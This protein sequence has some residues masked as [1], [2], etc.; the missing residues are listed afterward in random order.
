ME[1][2]VS[3]HSPDKLTK[4]NDSKKKAEISAI[5]EKYNLK[6][7]KQTK[8]NVKPTNFEIKPNPNQSNVVHISKSLPTTPITLPSQQS[9]ASGTKSLTTSPI[10]SGGG[11]TTKEISIKNIIEEDKKKEQ[12]KKYEMPKAIISNT[13]NPKSKIN[14]YD[15]IPTVKDENILPPKT[16]TNTNTN[17]NYN[18]P[19]SQF[20]KLPLKQIQQPQQMPM[21]RQ[22]PIQQQQ[23]IQKPVAK[24][25]QYKTV[26]INPN[27][28]EDESQYYKGEPV[29][30]KSISNNVPT[31]IKNIMQDKLGKDPGNINDFRT[32]RHNVNNVDN[33]VRNISI[34]K[35]V[36][37]SPKNMQNIQSLQNMQNAPLVEQV[38]TPVKGSNGNKRGGGNSG[39][40]ETSELSNLEKQRLLLQRQ[41]M[42]ELQKFKAKKAEIIKLNNRKKEIE[43]MRSI[44]DEKQKL[45]KIQEKQ[46]ELNNIY[47]QQLH[48]HSSGQN[49]LTTKNII[50]NVDAKRT[51]KNI[52]KPNVIDVPVKIE[53][54]KVDEKKVDEK[55][56]E[57]KKVEEK[58]VEEKK[59]DEKKA[60]GKE[61]K[62]ELKLDAPLEY[63][64]KKD[65]PDIKWP[66][67]NE[68]YDVVT[69]SE[70]L[71][72]ILGAPNFFNKKAQRDKTSKE[73]INKTMQNL[74]G[75]KHI[76][77][78]KDT[79]I[80]T[81]YKILSYEKIKWI[82]E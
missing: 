41:Q 5:L 68:L 25:P 78:F 77:K 80:S 20:I 63:Y 56:V 2:V 70:S 4:I 27:L 26:T 34:Q 22:M 51:K 18:K 14:I 12:A 3:V 45:R 6:P 71:T 76:D 35:Q 72:T 46:H 54:K 40:L 55:K 11:G 52:Q 53:E 57:E 43:L 47:N 30:N 58:K 67:K 9:S 38:L 8:T 82:P 44:E 10:P 23:N 1:K 50:Y 65:K 81:I 13:N 39:N 62:K 59:V 66:T 7:T 49:N 61:V 69:F 75:F 15:F 60:G 31:P 28:S 33:V 48:N 19:V 73:D 21:Q 24:E 32:I 42:V 29:S 16:N 36:K 17:T 74:Y 64:S 79:L 37:T